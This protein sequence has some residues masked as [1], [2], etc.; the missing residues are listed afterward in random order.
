MS[1]RYR[2]IGAAV[3][4]VTLGANLLVAP[5]AAAPSAAD[6]ESSITCT[7]TGDVTWL[8]AGIGAV[9]LPVLWRASVTFS[10][11]TGPGISEINA[12][13]IRMDLT[14][15]EIVACDGPVEAHEGSGRITW[16]DGTFSDV[17]ETSKNQFKE[18]GSGPGTFPID[19]ESGHFKG[20]E[21]IDENEV[22]LAGTC[23]GASVGT[24]TGTFHIR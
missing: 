20:H 9:A 5:G 4:G 2:L 10:D 7:E 15:T 6:D 1:S 14:G 12:K 17:S 24:L 19:I 16:S 8:N 18:G 23:P 21:A 22:E 11:C 3:A 13:P